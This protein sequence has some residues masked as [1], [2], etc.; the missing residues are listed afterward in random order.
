MP[1]SCSDSQNFTKHEAFVVIDSMIECWEFNENFNVEIVERIKIKTEE[2]EWEEDE[3]FEIENI[4][5]QD[6]R[7]FT[8]GSDGLRCFFKKDGNEGSFFLNSSFKLYFKLRKVRR[9]KY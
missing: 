4:T 9:K 7:K 2:V 5:T 1:E 3:I 8:D 6:A